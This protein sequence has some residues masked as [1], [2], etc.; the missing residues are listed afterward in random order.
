MVNG[1]SISCEGDRVKGKWA[2]ISCEGGGNELLGFL[3]LVKERGYGV[4]G[5]SVSSDGRGK[6]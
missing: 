3:Y 2:F 5:F 4:N 1:L 6:R